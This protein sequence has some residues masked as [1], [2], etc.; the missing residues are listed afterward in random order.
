MD[1]KTNLYE[2]FAAFNGKN[3]MVQCLTVTNSPEIV[4]NVLRAAGV[5]PALCD[6]PDEAGQLAG[7]ADGIHINT[8]NL[9]KEAFRAIELA[10]DTANTA[11]TPWVLDPVAI[12]RLDYR[13][14]F[15]RRLCGQHPTCIRGNV[16]EITVLT[17][18]TDVGWAAHNLG[19]VDEVI[20][21][22]KTL[23][24]TTGAVVA[25]SGDK[26]A[27]VSPDG[28]VTRLT[29]GHIMQTQLAG[30]GSSLSAVT[31]AYLGAAKDC[32]VSAHDA[33]VAA[34]A[35]VGAAG[36]FA[37]KKASG[38]GTFGAHFIDGI[39]RQAA[40]AVWATVGFADED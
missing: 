21:A 37:A 17:G 33:V 5:T 34:H 27:I 40:D 24:D 28:R 11:G 38:P 14:Q 6:N 1:F 4:A 25:V 9:S 36:M 26:D 7:F 12:G 16:R 3:I 39:Y 15:A 31:A 29:C 10:V 13:T 23:A 18:G 2:A 32:P 35:H 22:A 20:P 8:A 30:M 19:R